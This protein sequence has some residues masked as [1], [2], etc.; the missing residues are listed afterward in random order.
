MQFISKTENGTEYMQPSELLDKILAEP[1]ESKIAGLRSVANGALVRALNACYAQARR[2]DRAAGDNPNGFEDQMNAQTE[3]DTEHIEQEH[4]R[5]IGFTPTKS[6]EERARQWWRIYEECRQALRSLSSS[7]YDQPMVP[8]QMWNWMI[9]NS[10]STK[11]GDSKL[12]AAAMTAAGIDFMSEKDIEDETKKILTDEHDQ[13][14]R[15]TPKVEG[16]WNSMDSTE[17]IAENEDNEL[18][19]QNCMNALNAHE[20]SSLI[21]SVRNGLGRAMNRTF[22]SMIRFR[23]IQD[24]GTITLI[25][26]LN[27]SLADLQEAAA[28]AAAADEDKA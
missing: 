16:I 7:A 6:P 11:E 23:R 9:G 10:T 26:G 2:E 21:N 25:K 17:Q 20:F 1:R 8:H 13:M 19:Y 28:N 5:E 18:G 15:L 14:T 22:R 24:A 4:V 27:D 12:Y 3:L